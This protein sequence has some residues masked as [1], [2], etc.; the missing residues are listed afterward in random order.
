MP[1]LTTITGE[2][3]SAAYPIGI[4]TPLGDNALAV[5]FVDYQ[6]ELGGLFTCDVELLR[7]GDAFEPED[8]LGQN[9]T[10]RI[11]HSGHAVV[12]GFVSHVFVGDRL[13]V[14][15]RLV[16]WTWFLT[17][18]SDCR[19]FQKMKV[20]DIIGQ[21]FRDMGFTDF[22]LQINSGDYR[23]W[24]YCVQYRETAFNF[25]S[26]LMEQEGISYYFRHE[27][28][29]HVMV[30]CDASREFDMIGPPY[31]GTLTFAP[32]S[33]DGR[34][35][36]GLDT[37][38]TSTDL[39]PGAYVLRDFDFK[40]PRTT[41]ES[42]GMVSREHVAS[43]YELYEYP[44]EYVESGDGDRY[45][46]LRI[47]E[48][49][50]SYRVIHASGDAMVVRPGVRFRLDDLSGELS[51]VAEGEYQVVAVRW[52]ASQDLSSVA[53]G[54]NSG[55]QESF[56]CNLSILPAQTPY[57][58][59]RRTPK[60]LIQGP[61]TAMVVGPSGEEI[62]TDEYGRVKI[63]FHWDRYSRADENSSCWV[64]V[65]QD[66]AGKKWGMINIPRIGQEVI[67]EFLEGD[68]DRPIITGRVYNAAC[69]P[70]YDL[71]A[72][73][74]RTTFKTNSSKGGGGFNEV[75]FEDKKGEEQIFVHAQKQF[76]RR[77]LAD[78]FHWIGNDQHQIVKKKQYELVEEDRHLIIKG[79][80]KQQIQGDFNDSFQGDHL[81]GIAGDQHLTVDKDQILKIGGNQDADVTGNISSKAG[82]TYSVQANDVM[83]KASM[84]VGVEG[85]MNVHI[86]AGMNAVIEGGVGL[87]IKVG[88]N[89]ISINPGGVFIKGTL[90]MINS[91]GAAGSGGGCSPVSPA[92]AK[93][94]DAPEEAKEADT[95][96]A[97]QVAQISPPTPT[98]FSPAAMAMIQASAHS[99]PFC[100]EC[101]RAM[102]LG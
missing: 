100:E 5:R 35:S 21:V 60:P 90:V 23:K 85:G 72:N 42:K 17:R 69:M 49:H 54:G 50:S 10:I 101:A 53:G 61:Q 84:N 77:V 68:P 40:K 86:K 44:G 58:S 41:L 74:T 83:E 91:G 16:P 19:I 24:E 13:E 31:D 73:Q 26:R 51:S 9:V 27:E 22:E 34:E 39:Q 48:N 28:G 67:I 95:D 1:S 56:R 59:R 93:A 94:P 55:V 6:Q 30:L 80:V 33:E 45:A 79:D 20:P 78:D 99:A 38:R 65:S 87:T 89:F 57:R 15:L 98:E 76:D 47:Q 64:R 75:R 36:A 70:P 32:P 92:S 29:R 4:N 25:V 2:F 63:Q 14:R 43:D 71:P 46:T 12:N 52:R 11:E 8:L 88:G 96:Q 37:W 102:G 62:W 18:T 82:L 97:G 7:M 66:W 81:T 3:D